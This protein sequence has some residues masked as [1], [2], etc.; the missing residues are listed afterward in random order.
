MSSL[1][2]VLQIIVALG[3]MN[4][5]LLRSSRA[6]PYRGGSAKTMREEFTAYGLPYWFMC[7]VGVL[8]ISLALGLLG[9]IW[10]RSAAQ[11]AAFGMGALM[12]GALVMHIKVKDPVKKSLPASAVLAMC[13]AIAVL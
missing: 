9:A 6:T 5:W 13:L 8:K 7:L 11:P 3:I 12:V 1:T 4:V 10:F 2:I